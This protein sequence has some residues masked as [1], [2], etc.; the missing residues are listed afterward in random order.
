MRGAIASAGGVKSAKIAVEVAKR[1]E[2]PESNTII[3]KS[4]KMTEAELLEQL[5]EKEKR[6]K[7]V[8]EMYE[9]Q[10]QKT[11]STYKVPD[12]QKGDS[13]RETLNTFKKIVANKKALKKEL[14]KGVNVGHSPIES[15]RKFSKEEEEAFLKQMKQHSVYNL[16]SKKDLK[17]S[18]S[19][20][21]DSDSESVVP[22]PV[23]IT[24]G[25]KTISPRT[26]TKAQKKIVGF[27]KIIKAKKEK[28]G[29]RKIAQ[30]QKAE[31]EAEAEI[32]RSPTMR[33]KML[34][35][36]ENR[37]KEI[38]EYRR[39]QE[40]AEKLKRNTELQIQTYEQLKDE[41]GKLSPNEIM[42]KKYFKQLRVVYTSH[43]KTLGVKY[44][45]STVL[46]QLQK[47]EDAVQGKKSSIAEAKARE[48][49][50]NAIEAKLY[51]GE[52]KTQ[53]SDNIVGLDDILE[54]REKSARHQRNQ[55]NP[56]KNDFQVLLESG[57][58]S[59]KSTSRI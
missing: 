39:I 4:K 38:E 54:Q 46:K 58:S 32:K 53:R 37:Y 9:R 14:S 30:R 6:A 56:S 40:E 2:M 35:S 55:V 12:E 48:A 19:T 5:K 43:N 49:K 36:A 27:Q 17:T 23:S 13:Q 57:R 47:W 26:A 22:E 24:V 3:T 44:K 50:A 31:A 51:K 25:S 8:E 16:R 41:L 59:A 45:V 1:S 21:S 33:E 15:G 29:L 34:Q 18:R 7:K 11:R 10:K 42:P 28:I 20:G 52:S